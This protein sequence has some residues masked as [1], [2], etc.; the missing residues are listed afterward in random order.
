MAEQHHSSECGSNAEQER[1]RRIVR[2][3]RP[4]THRFVDHAAPIMTRIFLRS[5][6][7]P[8]IRLSFV[9]PRFRRFALQRVDTM[10]AGEQRLALDEDDAGS[11][12]ELLDLLLERFDR[13]KIKCRI[14]QLSW[15]QLIVQRGVEER[16]RLMRS[17]LERSASTLERL[18]IGSG[19]WRAQPY[20]L[21]MERA[22][23]LAASDR[24]LI[25]LPEDLSTV[26][27]VVLFDTLSRVLR[28]DF[29]LLDE[30][31]DLAIAWPFDKSGQ[32][33]SLAAL[34][35]NAENLRF[36]HIDA[37]PFR[38][39]DSERPFAMASHF[40]PKPPE[41]NEIPFQIDA[42]PM[43]LE[44]T[45]I[46]ETFGNVADAEYSTSHLFAPRLQRIS[47]AEAVASQ[48]LVRNLLRRVHSPRL[49][50]I[51]YA[52]RCYWSGDTACRA[53]H[54][55]ERHACFPQFLTDHLILD[56]RPEQRKTARIRRSTS[57]YDCALVVWLHHSEDDDGQQLHASAA[58]ETT[59]TRLDPRC[60]RARVRATNP[61]TAAS[62]MRQVLKERQPDP[63]CRLL[64]LVAGAGGH[65][66]HV[67]LSDCSALQLC[68][69]VT[70]A[71]NRLD[72]HVVAGIGALGE[73][74]RRRVDRLSITIR[75]GGETTVATVQL[76][77]RVLPALRRL[78][79][80]YAPGDGTSDLMRFVALVRAVEADCVSMCLRRV[81]FVWQSVDW[82]DDSRP[83]SHRTS[84]FLGG[85][86][87]NAR[88]AVL[89]STM[90]NDEDAGLTAN[91]VIA[92]FCKR[93]DA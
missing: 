3:C 35:S 67:P 19:G 56:A 48:T 55:R 89:R 53:E 64:L 10:I 1:P 29:G 68:S 40:R 15:R 47:I 36:L 69:R 81:H 37:Q 13:S 86:E 75:S 5:H 59:R 44:S 8:A 18:W 88:T 20:N 78:K 12:S 27:I 17:L 24:T 49:A 93:R 43:R 73:D 26:P 50:R 28:G 66:Q 2:A 61:E 85:D 31:R 79:L 46:T 6:L 30:L 74:I 83:S 33:A 45:S 62:T 77:M 76:L 52:S 39:R 70:L 25:A 14:V 57:R 16:L 23:H 7:V 60:G 42:A 4:S 51:D 72:E 87:A 65:E 34:I 38:T 11:E 91:A 92:V 41:P 32:A 90:P 71:V 82:H 58:L 9:S 63:T 84:L 21:Y 54:L 80:A 22:S